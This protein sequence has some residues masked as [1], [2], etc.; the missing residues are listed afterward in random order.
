M[1]KVKLDDGLWIAKSGT[2][3]KESEALIMP[4]MPTAQ[5]QLKKARR[6]LPYPNAMMIAENDSLIQPRKR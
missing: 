3:T 5:E 4:D 1:W 2:T 6:F